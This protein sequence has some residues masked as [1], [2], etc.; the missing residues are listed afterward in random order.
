MRRDALIVLR[1]WNP[2]EENKPVLPEQDADVSASK[3]D[4]SPN[5]EE[6]LD[7]LQTRVRNYPEKKWKRVQWAV[8]ALLGFL[9]GA[10]LTYFANMESIGMAGTI[11]AVLIALL[12]PN[13]IEKRVRRSIRNGRTALILAL[14][15]WLVG[16]MVSMLIQGVPII[17]PK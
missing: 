13:M 10:L 17:Q 7:E 4:V 2:L 14:A 9:C 8:G 11:G 3:Q 15:V 1:R 16:Y 5:P 12:A 6:E